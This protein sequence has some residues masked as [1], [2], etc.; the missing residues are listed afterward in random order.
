M[1]TVNDKV[2][3]INIDILPGNEVKPPLELNK[4]YSIREIILDKRGNQHLD[5]GLLSEYNYI[6]S[7]ETKEELDR[8]ALIHWCHPSRF[9]INN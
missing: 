8:G 9:K 4:E 7:F 5:I 3:C 1:Y 6:R 2:V